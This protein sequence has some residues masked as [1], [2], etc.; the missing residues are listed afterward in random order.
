MLRAVHRVVGLGES[1]CKTRA[2]AADASGW[3]LASEC[4]VWPTTLGFAALLRQ[5]HAWFCK[6]VS[7]ITKELTPRDP[8]FDDFRA[9][10][11][12]LCQMERTYDSV[13][14]RRVSVLSNTS[15]NSN[16]EI[17]NSNRAEDVTSSSRSQ[18]L[19]RHMS[20]RGAA[21]VSPHPEHVRNA[22][23]S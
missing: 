21:R 9:S 12:R 7:E 6:S 5:V 10:R 19:V 18:T 1:S 2:R 14:G 11:E 22:L 23:G 13:R 20:E 17:G 16:L 8:T 3:T 15:N 4:G